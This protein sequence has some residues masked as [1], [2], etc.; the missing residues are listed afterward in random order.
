MVHLCLSMTHWE[1]GYIVQFSWTTYIP[2]DFVACVLN[3]HEKSLTFFE[4]SAQCWYYFVPKAKIISSG[5][6]LHAICSLQHTL[7]ICNP[8]HIQLTVA[9]PFKTCNRKALFFECGGLVRGFLRGST[10]CIVTGGL[11]TNS[12][13]CLVTALFM[14]SNWSGITCT[15]SFAPLVL[16]PSNPSTSS[17]EQTKTSIPTTFLLLFKLF[18]KLHKKLSDTHS[19]VLMEGRNRRWLYSS[20]Q[21]SHI[22]FHYIYTTRL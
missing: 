15:I 4:K 14:N 21:I 8:W 17:K 19:I 20:W 5:W 9:L 3:E 16:I 18:V 13:C 1:L 6:D 10:Y 22:A 7:T 2:N 12:Q 11:S